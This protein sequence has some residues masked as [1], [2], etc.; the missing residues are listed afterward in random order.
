MA[1]EIAKAY[2]QIV[3]STKGIKDKLKEILGDELDKTGKNTGKKMGN[4]IV[5][6][7]KRTLVSI[8]IGKIIQST[9]SEGAKLEQSFGGLDT[10]YGESSDMAKQFARD[11]SSAGISMN[12]YAE[13]AVSFGASLRQAYGKDTA[14]AVETANMAILDMADNSAKMGTPLESI[15]NAYQGFA[16]QNYTMLDNLKLGYGGTKKEMERLLA[17]AEK[18]SGVHYDINNLGD[19]YNAIHV[20]QGELGITG[21][22]SY[23]A[24]QTLS[25][26]F[27]AMKASVSNFMASLTMGEDIRQPLESL[28]TA[29][30]NFLLKNLVPSIV[31]IFTEIPNAIGILVQSV[32]VIMEENGSSITEAVN[33]LFNMAVTFLSEQMP[34]LVEQGMAMVQEFASGLISNLPM[35]LA[36]GSELIGALLNG[37]IKSIPSVIA[38]IIDLVADIINA[39][40]NTDW[41][42][43]GMNLLNGIGDGIANAIPNLIEKAIK[44][45]KHLTD[46]IKNFFGIKSPSRLFRDEIGQ[47]LPSGIAVGIETNMDTVHDAMDDLNNATFGAIKNGRIRIEKGSDGYINMMNQ[48]LSRLENMEININ[49]NTSLALDGYTIAK[50]SAPYTQ[51]QLNKLTSINNRIKGV[52]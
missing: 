24:S 50:A 48:M 28:V 4:S 33:N 9:I 13:Q 39:I 2:V 51:T 7:L 27:N 43:V 22:A 30:S 8:G 14:S 37:I 52:K 21:V 20:I 36:K 6:S 34:Q 17:D 19:V 18:F 10:I 41:A 1:N 12:D 44:A 29:T 15:Q 46:A 40:A 32:G 25:G 45:C 49:N 47:F 5:S 31:R 16:K 38:T 26:S 35:I 23:E 42:T 3:P 11:A